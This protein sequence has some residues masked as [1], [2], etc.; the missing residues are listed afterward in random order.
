MSEFSLYFATGFNPKLLEI[1]FGKWDWTTRPL[2]C[3][4]TF[5][6]VKAW[7]TFQDKLDQKW[8]AKSKILD[9]GAYSVWKSGH[10]IDF[11]AYMAEAL[12]PDW[13]HVVALD[14]IGSAEGSLNNAL[15]SKARGL[16]VIPVFH[17]GEP[18][19]ILLEYKKQFPY[20]GIG[21]SH[22]MGKQI[23]W[24]EQ[25]FAR[26]YPHRIHLFG[27]SRLNL[28]QKYPFFSA[29]TASWHTGVRF[30]R[31]AAVPDIR[32][33]KVKEVG[34]SAYDIRVE[35]AHYLNIEAEVQACWKKEMAQFS[36]P[37]PKLLTQNV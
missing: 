37:V 12:K 4:V 17:Y 9:S 2:N 35:L 30:G 10:T 5:P 8:P 23:E 28:L 16:N 34:E 7:N 6:Y 20:I 29:D 32:W 25:C 22:I 31:L 26:V 13:D 11:E 19:D 24:L 14:V 15:A 18:W 33:P 21:G 3:L 36:E 27:C 1:T